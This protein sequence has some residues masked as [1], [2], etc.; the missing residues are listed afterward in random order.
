MAEVLCT[1]KSLPDVVTS[2]VM[3]TQS[4]SACACVADNFF[5]KIGQAIQGLH[6]ASCGDVH[7]KGVAGFRKVLLQVLLIELQQ[8]L[9]QLL[10]L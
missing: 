1:H 8:H 6:P 10:L 5:L 4:G 9:L 3:W 2:Q 7:I